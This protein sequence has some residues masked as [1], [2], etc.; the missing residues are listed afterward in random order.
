MPPDQNDRIDSTGVHVSVNV[1]AAP[2]TV[3]SFLNDGPRFASW[4]GAFAG[5]GPMEGTRIDP[6]VGGEIRVAYPG[7]NFGI[8]KITAMES[9]KRIA[10]TWGY[11]QKAQGVPEGSTQ[12]EITLTP[13]RD[14]T[15]VQLS[16]TGLPSEEAR[17]GHLGG[18][19]HYLAMLARDA[20][21]TQH[22]AAA[23][24]AFEAYF[25]A[26]GEVDQAAR[27]RML[28]ESCETDVRVRTQFACTDGLQKLSEHIAG[29]LKHMAGFTLR[30]EGAVETTHGYARV[31]WSVL[32][33]GG[34]PMMRGVNMAELSLG[35]K[36]ASVVSFPDPMT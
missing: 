30:A 31:P 1:S 10:F 7:G 14:G 26:W 11:E 32:A 13:T 36:L 16:H 22:Q 8:G 28:A 18:W 19:K 27:L 23:Q 3:W 35:G 34:N 5:Q 29:S 9:G 24:K 6:R 15:L 2:A 12:I 4:I 17:Q 33:P 21:S 25:R 20:A